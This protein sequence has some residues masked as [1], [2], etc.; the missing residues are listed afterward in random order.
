MMQVISETDL[1]STLC[2]LSKKWGG[3]TEL[4]RASK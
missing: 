3:P 4:Q 1:L 2:K